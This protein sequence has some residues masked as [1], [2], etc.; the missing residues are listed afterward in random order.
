M[1]AALNSSLEL[2]KSIIAQQKQELDKLLLGKKLERLMV[3]LTAEI[4][5]IGGEVENE[6]HSE[7][8]YKIYI[9]TVHVIRMG[10]SK[11]FAQWK[12]AHGSKADPSVSKSVSSLELAANDLITRIAGRISYAKSPATHTEHG[13]RPKIPTN[14]VVS[15][16]A[17]RTPTSSKVE[18]QRSNLPAPVSEQAPSEKSIKIPITTETQESFHALNP[19]VQATSS[20]LPTHTQDQVFTSYADGLAMAAPRGTRA[21]SARNSKAGSKAS[22]AAKLQLRLEEAEAEI[23]ARFSKEMSNRT[24]RKVTRDQKREEEEQRRESELRQKQVEEEQRRKSEL[25]RRKSELRQRQVEDEEEE[26]E[27]QIRKKKASIQARKEIIEA[28]DEEQSEKAKSLSLGIGYLEIAPIDK[29]AAYVGSLKGEKFEV[30]IEPETKTKATVVPNRSNVKRP[31]VTNTAVSMNNINRFS[32]SNHEVT[33]L[34]EVPSNTKFSSERL[35]YTT[36]AVGLHSAWSSR[37]IPAPTTLPETM[38]KLDPTPDIDTKAKLYP[39]S[40]PVTKVEIPNPSDYKHLLPPLL[41][42]TH[43]AHSPPAQERFQYS[44]AVDPNNADRIIEAMC[45]QMAL[46]RLPPAEPDVFDGQDQLRF[47]I[48]RIA[49]DSLISYGNMTDTNKLNL[50]NKYVGGQVK[51]AIEGY[52]LL[53]PSEA[54]QAAYNLLVKRYGDHYNMAKA[55]RDRLR[56]W[57]KVGATDISGL[58]DFVD[59]LRQCQIAQRKFEVLKSFNDEHENSEMVRKLPAWL[60]RQWARKVAAQRESI[61]KYPTFEEFVDF[62][63]QEDIYAHD[64]LARALQRPDTVKEKRRGSSFASD[65]RSGGFGTGGGKNFGTCIYCGDHHSIQICKKFGSIPFEARQSF[66]RDHQLCFSCLVRGHLSRECKNKKIC[67]I[68]QRGHPTSLHREDIS[69]DDHNFGSAHYSMRQ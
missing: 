37:P 63:S 6:T 4:E 58:R 33:P 2:H 43:I 21:G 44:G 53:P 64:S 41:E 65:S 56:A 12:D 57:P 50:L 7:A 51:A 42:Q 15:G 52:L 23:E 10:L 55:F 62:L 60:S 35:T 26:R 29:A 66:V 3:D 68:C 32:S 31:A 14:P 47:P 8:N 45:T 13:A 69:S 22:S 24:R 1:K 38:F 25:Q 48:W 34:S 28:Y 36:P 18:A 5:R 39:Y 61:G 19:G 9:D 46:S 59:F 17:I 67:Q 20:A 16:S 30:E 49:F 11:V 40:T 54:F 27:A